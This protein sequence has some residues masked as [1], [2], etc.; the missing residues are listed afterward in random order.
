MKTKLFT[1]IL[2]LFACTGY[3]QEKISAALL[4]EIQKAQHDGTTVEAMIWLTDQYDTDALDRQLTLQN[5]DAHQRGMAVVT[6][7]MEHA[8]TTQG[9][10]LGFLETR[11]NTDVIRYTPYWITNVIFIE[12]KPE[13]LYEL[14]QQPDVGM[15]EPNERF[16]SIRPV[17]GQ[18]A[19]KM[20]GH[21][22]PGLKAI[23]AHKMW[24]LGFTGEGVILGCIPH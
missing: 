3:S 23:N 22:E 18:Q 11:I 20:P 24:Q 6:S 9:S 7:L 12:T 4:E 19:P 13:F 14:A 17:A 2:I 5:A 16:E 1:I 8:Q 15:L 10:L 21:A